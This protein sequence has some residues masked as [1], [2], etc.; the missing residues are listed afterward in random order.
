MGFLAA[1][2]RSIRSSKPY[3]F[4]E[5]LFDQGQNYNPN[6]GVYLVPNSG[7]YYISTQL[8]GSRVQYM[9]YV[10]QVD[11]KEIL[12]TREPSAHIQ[13]NRAP[14]MSIVYHLKAGQELT[15]S[16]VTGVQYTGY[17]TGGGRYTSWFGATLL[18][19]D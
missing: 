5:V 13:D 7:M 8:Y 4:D 6:T 19:M 2:S 1:Y 3:K 15:V 16:P 9:D 10:I 18:Y 11:G 14:S 17:H 12:Y